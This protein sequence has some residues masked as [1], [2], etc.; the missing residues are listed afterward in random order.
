MTPELYREIRERIGSRLEVAR[1]IG[2]HPETLR[3]RESGYD[4]HP[5]S[6]ESALA[7]IAAA[8]LVLDDDLVRHA[9]LDYVDRY[10]PHLATVVTTRGDQS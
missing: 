3:K 8:S 4:A 9:V 6:H 7:I 10:E 2:I 5:I 1:L